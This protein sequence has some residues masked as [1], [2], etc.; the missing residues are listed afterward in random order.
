VP[1]GHENLKPIP[2]T[3]GNRLAERHGFYLTKVSLSEEAEIEELASWFGSR[4]PVQDTD[5]LEPLCQLAAGLSW[6]IRRGYADLV[7]N[8]LTPGARGRPAPI[9]QRL[10]ACERLLL[11]VLRTL[12]MSPQAAADLGLTLA[13]AS[14]I[15]AGRLDLG[16]LDDQERQRLR[17]LLEKAT[18]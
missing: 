9:L 10:E 14:E 1:R 5:A 2:A 3:P 18:G 16:R 15:Q 7:P 13:R 8:G 12:G 17:E 11:D 6:R 4:A